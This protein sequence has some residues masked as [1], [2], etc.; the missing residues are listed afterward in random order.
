MLFRSQI[1]VASSSVPPEDQPVDSGPEGS[2]GGGGGGVGGTGNDGAGGG[3]IDDRPTC[4]VV[5]QT[6]IASPKDGY[7]VYEAV[8]WDLRNPAMPLPASSQYM[9]DLSA[10]YLTFSTNPASE[11]GIPMEV[12]SFPHQSN[13]AYFL[14]AANS[15]ADEILFVRTTYMDVQNAIER[16]ITADLQMCL[17]DPYPAM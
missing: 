10:W 2:G 16:R 9:Q 5:R 3:G 11:Y 15:L 12:V 6:E 1:L 14:R 17:N 13:A 4:V 7:V 8:L